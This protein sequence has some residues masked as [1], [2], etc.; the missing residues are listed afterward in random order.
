MVVEMNP[1]RR[2]GACWTLSLG[3]VLFGLLLAI[4]W[5]S[6]EERGSRFLTNQPI[7]AWGV[8]G[9][10]F[11]NCLCLAWLWRTNMTVLRKMGLTVVALIPLLGPV[12]VLPVAQLPP[13]L[14]RPRRAKESDSLT[15]HRDDL[16]GRFWHDN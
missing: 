16:L 12:L 7:I 4:A 6:L 1:S 8:A 15:M 5:W 11:F 13:V 9:S 14:P 10:F 2:Q 3:L